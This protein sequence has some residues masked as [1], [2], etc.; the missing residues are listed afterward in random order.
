V[1]SFNCGLDLRW[2]C[3]GSTPTIGIW[4]SQSGVMA[5]ITV[6]HDEDAGL[7]L[8]EWHLQGYDHTLNVVVQSVIVESV[9]QSQSYI[10]ARRLIQ[11]V[12]T[13]PSTLEF[14][15]RELAF[16]VQ[17]HQVID[18]PKSFFNTITGGSTIHRRSIS[19]CCLMCVCWYCIDWSWVF[20]YSVCGVW[21][22]FPMKFRI[23]LDFVQ[24]HV[25]IKYVNYTS[26]WLIINCLWG[27]VLLMSQAWLV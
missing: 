20:M 12:E 5:A 8:C 18:G 17:E 22:W 11:L 25:C 6:M 26:E 19:F 10:H 24:L 21:L 4:W 14:W 13:E 7:I 3:F 15:L 2:P 27:L 16:W 1:I 9:L 23:W